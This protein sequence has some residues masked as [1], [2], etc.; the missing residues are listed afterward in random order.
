MLALEIV[1]NVPLFTLFQF[2]VGQTA[3]FEVLCCFSCD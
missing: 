1:I 2:N 3:C